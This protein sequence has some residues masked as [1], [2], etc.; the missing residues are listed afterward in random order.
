MQNHLG[1]KKWCL[2]VQSPHSSMMRIWE[3]ISNLKNNIWDKCQKIR[4]PI[5]QRFLVTALAVENKWS[6]EAISPRQAR[7]NCMGDL[8]VFSNICEYAFT[9]RSAWVTQTLCSGW[10][11]IPSN[12]GALGKGPEAEMR[13]KAVGSQKKGVDGLWKELRASFPVLFSSFTE[14]EKSS[15]KRHLHNNTF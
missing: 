5:H 1:G 8:N 4:F 14:R 7:K 13:A 15:G 9:C 2:T 11:Q 6:L 12:S 3:M 10:A